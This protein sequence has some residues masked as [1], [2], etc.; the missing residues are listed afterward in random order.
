MKS[1]MNKKFDEKKNIFHAQSMYKSANT[2]VYCWFIC[3][4][5]FDMCL[6]T[7]TKPSMDIPL[8]AQ[9]R[10]FNLLASIIFYTV[11]WYNGNELSS[12][13]FETESVNN[14]QYHF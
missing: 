5:S 4:F 14:M 11:D 2:N 9:I 12:N 13:I 6:V 10:S 8:V 1:T 3:A 7:L